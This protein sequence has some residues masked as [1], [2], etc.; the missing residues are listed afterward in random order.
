[1]LTSLLFTLRYLRL[2]VSLL[3]PL[4]VA[5][6]V[7]F[8]R[9]EP[10]VEGALAC[11]AGSPSGQTVTQNLIDALTTPFN[12][13]WQAKAPTTIDPYTPVGDAA[14]EL[15]NI[16][17]SCS[18][19]LNEYC[20]TKGATNCSSAYA[21]VTLQNLTGLKSLY[22]QPTAVKAV[23]QKDAAAHSSPGP[24][25]GKITDGVLAAEGSSWN[26]PKYV[27]VL[28]L[29]GP[30]YAITIDLGQIMPICGNSSCNSVPLI[31]AN[32][33]DQYV[34]DYSA[35]GSTWTPFG[36]FLKVSSALRSRSMTPVNSS[37]EFANARYVRVY[38]DPT[39]NLSDGNFSVSELRLWTSGGAEIAPG[40]KAIGPRPAQIT[41]GQLG[42]SGCCWNDPHY[43]VNLGGAGPARALVIDLGGTADVCGSGSLGCIEPLITANGPDVY[44]LDYSTDGMNWI[45]CGQFPDT[46]GKTNLQTRYTTCSAP[47]FTARYL[48]LWGVSGDGNYT[49]SE[50][51]I[52]PNALV[53]ANI[54][55]G[56]LT[57]G[58]EPMVTNGEIPPDGTGWEDSRYAT[59]LPSC[60]GNNSR[61]VTNGTNKAV[62]SAVTIDL[63]AV[64][65]VS[66]LT[67]QANRTSQY[68]VDASTDRTSWTPLWTAPVISGTNLGTRS[69]GVLSNAQAQYLRV[70]AIAGDGAYSVSALQVFTPQANTA[71]AYDGGANAGENFACSYD[72]QFDPGIVLPGLNTSLT[73][74]FDL[75]DASINVHCD[76]EGVYH[77][78]FIVSR[79]QNTT[80]SMGLRLNSPAP[81]ADLCAGSCA[82]S[83]EGSILSYAQLP[84]DQLEFGPTE[85]AVSCDGGLDQ[86]LDQVL[87]GVVPGVAAGATQALFNGILDYRK[88]PNT[89]VPFPPKPG[90]CTATVSEPPLELPSPDIASGLSGR[91]TQVANVTNSATLR[92]QG[93]FTVKE[94]IALD[95]AVLTLNALLRERGV[96]EL[97]QGPGGALLVPLSLQPLKGSKP[98]KGLYQTAPGGWPIVSAQVEPVTGPGAQNGLMEFSLDVKRATI[99]SAPPCLEG[100]STVPLTTSFYLVGGGPAPVWVEGAAN[101]Q[102]NG[103]QLQTP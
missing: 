60:T 32:G 103:N 57:Y 46:P 97:V 34:M 63:G 55:L 56:K 20:L 96:G 102:C 47:H 87:N 76:F 9:G 24:D 6:P 42:P 31:Q 15:A 101:W 64:F 41:D 73:M 45:E 53:Q 29:P 71:C 66:Q 21:S 49:I 23:N 8:A 54:A 14:N 33:P 25:A 30:S 68:Q 80:C 91:A 78:W 36:T 61:C 93:R 77:Q 70:Y 89:L 1:V 40:A 11:P 88:K 17:I 28:P 58:P 26:D 99:L 48:R 83:K 7:G 79:T 13:A 3:L 72:A 59:V 22:F 86:G 2:A 82:S 44:Q 94:P 90:L 39:P 19:K 10:L 43:V 27:V 38:G 95:Q 75:V 65:P 5:W 74:N 100:A 51:Q 37:V 16:P 50:L 12:N 18:S 85:P 62:S 81:V 52:F 84:D 69:S 35:D 67:I 92:L 98:Y 4:A